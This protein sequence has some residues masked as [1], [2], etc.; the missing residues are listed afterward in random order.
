MVTTKPRPQVLLT[1]VKERC[2]DLPSREVA[3]GSEKLLRR[4][5]PI[6]TYTWLGAYLPTRQPAELPP[7]RRTETE[8]DRQAD[9]Q[10]GQQTDVWDFVRTVCV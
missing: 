6:R 4:V 5:I 10:A 2:S 9:R 8:R 7:D 3:S 1:A